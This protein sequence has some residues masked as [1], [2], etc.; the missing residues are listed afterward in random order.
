MISRRWPPRSSFYPVP[1]RKSSDVSEARRPIDLVLVALMNAKQATPVVAL[2]HVDGV[3]T[4]KRRGDEARRLRFSGAEQI[5][6]WPG[7]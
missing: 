5:S 1:E 7:E 4:V 2:L 3:E 6:S